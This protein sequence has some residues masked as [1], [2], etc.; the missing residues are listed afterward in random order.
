MSIVQPIC[1]PITHPLARALSS[2][3]VGG[4]FNPA[5]QFAANEPGWVYDINDLSTMF[6]DSAGTTAASVNNLVGLVL[7]KRLGLPVGS[8]ARTSG[9]IGLLGTATAAAYNSDAGAGSVTRVDASNQSFV[10]FTGLLAN[11]FYRLTFSAVSAAL[12]VRTGG[13]AGTTFSTVTAASSILCLADASGVLTITASA[14]ATVT[15]TLSGITSLRGSHAYQGATANKPVLRGTP[16]GANLASGATWTAGTD[17]S[18]AGST[19]TAT[20]SSGT[21]TAAAVTAIIGKTYRITFTITQTDGSLTASIGGRSGPARSASGTYVGYFDNT[22]TAAALVFTGSGF[23]GTVTLDTI[24]L[25]DVS[26]G[27]VAAPYGLQFDGA[28]D[29]LQTAAID[30]TATDKIFLCS[31]AQKLSDASVG[32]PYELSTATSTNS[33]AFALIHPNSQTLPTT[34]R[35]SASGS[36]LIETYYSNLSAAPRTDVFS[37]SIDLRGASPSAA[38]SGRTNGA[39]QTPY[40]TGGTTAGTGNFGNHALYIGRRAGTSFPFNG[41]LFS[42]V[43]RGGTLP[44]AALIT[45]YETWINKRTGAY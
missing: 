15:F 26:A 17:W 11:T 10:T 8:D 19:A 9:A 37:G 43:C 36:A 14:A 32:V 34:W 44:A 12:A 23:S 28:D 4:L 5:S 40:T 31:G 25:V 6:V 2:P 39:A 3:G 27:S 45:Q 38:I 13:V 33:G 21:L 29:F 42:S 16:T 22:T 7:D 41:L 1:R 24:E 18:V 30:F 20:L 35:L